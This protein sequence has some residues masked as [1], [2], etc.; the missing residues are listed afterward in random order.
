MARDKSNVVGVDHND[1]FAEYTDHSV[2]EH[3]K[4]ALKE[5]G[6]DW[7]CIPDDTL[8]G[9]FALLNYRDRASLASVCKTW[10][11]LASS[12]CLWTSLDLRAHS[13]NAEMALSLAGR[14]KKLQRVRFR[15]AGP[16]GAII[17]L[18]ARALRDLS[19]DGCRDLTDA[20]LSMLAARHEALESLQLGPD[21]ER[22]TSDAIVVVAVCCPN[23]KRLR[24]SGVRDVDGEAIRALVK[25]C[26]NL[27][28]LGFLDC[29]AVD[30]AVLGT[31]TSLRLLSV[32]GSRNFSWNAAA[33][34][35]SKLP[36]LIALDASR[37]EITPASASRLLAAH[38]L[39]VLCALNCQ[40]LEESSDSVV[41][42]NRSKVLLTRFTDIVKGLAFLSPKLPK[43]DI[44]KTTSEIGR[45]GSRSF[46]AREID[47]SCI[48]LTDWAEWVLS[49][50]LLRVAESNAPGLDSFWLKQGTTVML[51]LLRS[52]QEDVQERGA[53]AL[54]T[55]VVIDDENAT[56]DK[57]RAEA[58][59][60]SG[61]IASLLDL[62]K[63]CREGVQSESAKVKY[64]LLVLRSLTLR[65]V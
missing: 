55:F 54:A 49:H 36:N 33:H 13:L 62:A 22:L 20:T 28:E 45:N 30:E 42:S 56:V 34:S 4:C 46:G 38:Q 32:A 35:W 9:L 59:M 14:C 39:K 16:A 58:V 43:Y 31:A 26:P 12:S 51:S 24:L 11:S 50:A 52:K 48:G 41:Y 2:D 1:S 64:N 27:Q 7:T 53:T 60:N 65:F 18:Q 47:S 3:I 23:L 15:G 6:A 61:G 10:R 57:A 5:K 63:S 19:G 44:R 17:G 21:C 37:T 29:G 25:H 40:I 8:V